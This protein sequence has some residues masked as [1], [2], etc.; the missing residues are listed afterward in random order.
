MTPLASAAHQPPDRA[1]RRVAPVLQAVLALALLAGALAPPVHEM[2]EH[3]VRLHHLQH[4]ALLCGGGL[5]GLLLSRIVRQTGWRPFGARWPRWRAVALGVVLV[6]PVVVM[7]LMVPS[8]SPWT[9]EHPLAHALEHLLLI[10]LAMVIGFCAALL[11]PV[12]GWLTVL[13]LAAMAAAFGGMALAQ[14]PSLPRAAAIA[15]P[16]AAQMR[17]SAAPS[18]IGAVSPAPRMAQVRRWAEHT[19]RARLLRT[20]TAGSVTATL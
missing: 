10:G 2:A 6:G 1:W 14:P 8:T 4:A 11:T 13:L 12:L 7:V 18:Q 20:L 3:N 16:R 17:A 5:L 9:V 19:H 15:A